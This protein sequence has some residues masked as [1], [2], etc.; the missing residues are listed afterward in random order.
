MLVGVFPEIFEHLVMYS[1]NHRPLILE[2]TLIIFFRI[3]HEG[4]LTRLV[5]HRGMKKP[6]C[7][8]SV[9]RNSMSIPF[10]FNILSRSQLSV[11]QS[12]ELLLDPPR[13]A[14][15]R[16]TMVYHLVFG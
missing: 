11:K 2:R 3:H 5:R 4:P 10:N 15:L 16:F 6:A 7:V 1:G 13:H 8:P 12:S 9:R 14:R